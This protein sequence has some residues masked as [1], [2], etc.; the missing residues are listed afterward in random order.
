MLNKVMVLMSALAFLVIGCGPNGQT[1][2]NRNNSNSLLP[3]PDGQVVTPQADAAT[4]N[5]DAFVQPGSDAA[6]QPGSDAATTQ[7]DAATTQPDAATPTATP[8]D[9]CSCDSECPSVGGQAGLCVFGVCMIEASATCSAGGSQAECPAGSRCWGL[10]NYSGSICWPDCASYTCDGTCDSDGSCLASVGMDCDYTCG[11][12]CSCQAGDCGTNDQCV[13]GLCVP[14]TTGNGPGVGPGPT[15][16]NLPPLLCTGGATYCNDLVPFEPVTGPGYDNYPING[17]TISDQY[18]SY[19]RRD[20]RMLI[21]YA[22]AKVAC[23]TAGWTFGDNWPLG[24]GDMSEADGAIPGTS[25]GSLG[26]PPGT[27][28]DGYDIDLAYHQIGQINNYLRPICP[29][30]PGGTEA[31]HCTAPPDIL[32][33]WRTALFL[34]FLAE[35]PSLRVIGCDGQAGPILDAAITQLCTDGWLTTYA[36]GNVPLTYEVTDQGYGWFL[37]HHH[38]MHVSFD[39]PS[40]KMA[41]PLGDMPCKV[42]GCIPNDRH[43]LLSKQ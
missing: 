13:N 23:K 34:G 39:Q 6:V 21:Q 38:H 24:L 14:Q 19:I 37:F 36:C 26:H 31:Y 35:H 18:R 4:Q 3:G 22:T 12:Y 40:Y 9:A 17:E 30:T 2:S 8:G 5:A 11:S 32:D 41:L 25:I 43:P 28:T 10:T 7:P 29:H 15:C 27:H 20:L 33:E 42:L 16:S 1:D